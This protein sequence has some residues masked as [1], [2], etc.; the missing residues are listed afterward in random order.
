M[1]HRHALAAKTLPP[2]LSDAMSRVIKL[3]NYIKRSSF[4]TRLFRELSKDFDANSETLLFHTEVRWL[5][6]GKV[7]KRVFELRAEIQEFILQKNQ[8]DFRL[9]FNIYKQCLK[10]AYLVDIFFSTE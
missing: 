8:Q 2:L 1:L 4:N 9:H 5:S 7:V 3:V 6:R 10:L